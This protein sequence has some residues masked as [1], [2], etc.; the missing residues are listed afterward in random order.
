MNIF[1]QV[2]EEAEEK[3]FNPDQPRDD[4][5]RWGGGGAPA[6]HNPT[7][8]QHG[9]R[10]EG[11]HSLGPGTPNEHFPGTVGTHFA[12]RRIDPTSAGYAGHP[13]SLYASNPRA[14]SNER[15]AG[16]EAQAHHEEV[17]RLR[18]AGRHVEARALDR[19]G[20][21]RPKMNG[22]RPIVHGLSDRNYDALHPNL[23]DRVKKPK[24]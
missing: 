9:D 3:A 2:I 12:G 19:Q 15:A 24:K 8:Q 1:I 20:P 11:G 7:R 14:Y 16:I 21:A 18:F 22:G 23:R 13:N 5:G 10:A 4:H 17:N 6:S